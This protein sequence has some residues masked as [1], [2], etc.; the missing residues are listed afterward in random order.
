MRV[1]DRNL[2]FHIFFGML[3]VVAFEPLANS[4]RCNAHYGISFITNPHPYIKELF[5]DLLFRESL[6]YFLRRR[7]RG[8]AIQIH[9]DNVVEQFALSQCQKVAAWSAICLWFSTSSR[10]DMGNGCKNT[11]GIRFR[12]SRHLFNS[13]IMAFMG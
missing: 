1:S 6:S 9:L 2:D 12:C 4:H 10:N 5:G 8:A 11:R 13:A 7:P 3:K